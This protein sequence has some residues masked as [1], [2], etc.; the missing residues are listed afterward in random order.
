MSRSAKLKFNKHL[1]YGIKMVKQRIE[2]EGIASC[3][4]GYYIYNEKWTA[5]VGLA[6]LCLCGW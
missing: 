1:K 6:L 3:V 5:A 2:N 4:R